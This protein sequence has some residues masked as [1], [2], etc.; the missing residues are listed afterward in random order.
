MISVGVWQAVRALTGCCAFMKTVMT[1]VKTALS[2]LVPLLLACVLQVGCDRVPQGLEPEKLV[3]FTPETQLAQPGSC[4][5]NAVRVELLSRAVPGVLGGDGV[6]HPIE[7]ARLRVEPADPA[8]GIRAIPA[9]GVTDAGGTCTFSVELGKGFGDQYLDIV[10]VDAPEVRRRVRFVSGVTVANDRQE[11]T[12]GHPLPKPL[13]VTLTA[14]DGTPIGGAPVYFTLAHQPGKAGKLSKSSVKTDAAGVAEVTLKTDPDVTGRYE[15]RAE[16]ADSERGIHTRPFSIEALSMC[17]SRTLIG[18]VGGLAIFVFGMTLM[19]EGLHQVAGNRMK[20]VLAYVTRNRVAAIFAG[21]FVTALIQSSSATTVMTVGFVNAG[22][23]SLQQAI[24]VVFGANIGTTVTGQMVSFKLDGLALPAIIVGTGGLLLARRAA[25]QGVARTGLGFGLLFFGMSLMSDEL[26]SVSSFPSFVNVFHSFD[27]TPQPGGAMPLGA[28]LGA[29][30]IGTLMTMIVQSSSATIGLAIALANSGLLNFWTAVPIVLGDN[31]GTTI[32]AILASLNTNRT[33]RQTA[34]AH[35]MFNVFGTCIMAG[36]FYVPIGGIP[37]FLH[38]VNS[39]TPGNVF[40]GENLGR[41]VA[42][43]HTLFNVT[44]VV[45]MTPFIGALAWLCE[46]LIPAKKATT[47][48]VHLEKNLL[49]TP[50]LALFCAMRAL[51]DMTDTAWR[52]AALALRGYKDD[53]PAKVSDIEAMEDIVDRNQSEIMDYLVQLTRKELSE[54]QAAAIPVLMHC[55]NDA[56]RISDLALLIARR[57]ETQ[58]TAAR[59]S[60]EALEE[61]ELLLEKATTI[62][63]LTHESLQDGRFLAK[64][65]GIVVEDLETLAHASMQGHVERL[66]KGLCTPERGLI[67][68]EVVGAVENIVRHLENIA[69]RSDLLTAAAV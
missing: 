51:A 68:V 60:K 52:A 24:G 41:H 34:A 35:A 45:L 21:T 31:I 32:T 54:K 12:A 7:G 67:Y 22:L 10:C 59:F 27:C 2:V 66:Q 58:T 50:S 11:G 56:E 28:V 26:A 6:A 53:K 39:V 43:A 19:S 61:L 16:V 46:H 42:M 47:A 57:A 20:S 65:V 38:L 62:A 9:E 48:T 3:L 63:S 18:V 37:C 17:V 30:G 40:V 23:L 33:A 1:H 55:V 25:W 5:T 36:L 14:P 15:V 8:S 64:A 49:N 13:R 4:Q 44:N 29:I 69:Q